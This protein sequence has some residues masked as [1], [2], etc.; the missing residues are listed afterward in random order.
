MAKKTRCN[1]CGAMI[2]NGGAIIRNGITLCKDCGK[3]I[4]K[5]EEV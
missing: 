2:W 4:V 3:V 5:K 1:W